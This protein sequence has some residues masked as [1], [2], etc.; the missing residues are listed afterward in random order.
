MY[1]HTVQRKTGRFE[2]MK[3][4]PTNS[5]RKSEYLQ[6]AGRYIVAVGS[7]VSTVRGELHLVA[8]NWRCRRIWRRYGMQFSPGRSAGTCL[9]AAFY[10]ASI[11]HHVTVPANAPHHGRLTGSKH[12]HDIA[13]ACSSLLPVAFQ[14]CISVNFLKFA[15][16]SWFFFLKISKPVFKIKFLVKLTIYVTR[17]L[18][19]WFRSVYYLTWNKLWVVIF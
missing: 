12:G 4:F 7:R 6:W 13:A 18:I 1:N 3:L 16:I 11:N 2:Q 8:L 9:N 17:R 19:S 10:T 14:L 5:A 15:Y